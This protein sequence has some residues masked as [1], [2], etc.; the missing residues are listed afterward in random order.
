MFKAIISDLVDAAVGGI[1]AQILDINF[2]RVA[3]NESLE[4]GLVETI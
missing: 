4:L 2:G 3:A 1:G